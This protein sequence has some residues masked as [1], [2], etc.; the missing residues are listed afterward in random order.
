MPAACRLVDAHWRCKI[1]DF[2]L[3]RILEDRVVLSS[4]MATNPRWLAPE[5]LEGQPAT[6]ESVSVGA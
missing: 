2:N 4:A 3:S 1:S 5:V 6:L